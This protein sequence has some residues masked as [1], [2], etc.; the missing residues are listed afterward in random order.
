[1][2]YSCQMVGVMA[3]PAGFKYKDVFLKGRPQHS[4]YDNFSIKH[5]PMPAAKWAK[6]FSPFDALK[7]FSEAVASKDI[8]YVKRT[9]LDPDAEAELNRRLDIL[10]NLAWNSRMAKANHV[11]VTVTFFVP[12]SDE[13]NFAYGIAGSYK[14]VSGVLLNVDPEIAQTLSLRTSSGKHTISFEDILDV[15][16]PAG[17]FNRDWTSEK[18]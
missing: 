6:I 17:I 7:G 15:D 1:M 5:P 3:M 12:C 14:K 13:Q 10:H 8:Q 11:V 4:N 18:L 2:S 16:C 9:E